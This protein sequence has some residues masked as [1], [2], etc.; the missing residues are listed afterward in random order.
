MGMNGL[1][2]QAVDATSPILPSSNEGLWAA[3][4]LIV[5]LLVLAV[6]VVLATRYFGR[7]R[8]TA[9]EAA[10]RAGAA[11]HE[12]AALRAELREKGS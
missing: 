5:P 3:V 4:S 8:R 7:L 11:Q 6:P 9:E 2:A 10:S 12:V 1:L